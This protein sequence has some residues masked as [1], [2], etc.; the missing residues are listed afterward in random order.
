M[1]SGIFTTI[2]RLWSE[3]RKFIHGRLREFG[4]GS[5]QIEEKIQEELSCLVEAI[6]QFE[7]KPFDPNELFKVSVS[8]IICSILF[9]ERFDYESPAFKKYMVDLNENLD[10]ITAAGPL[11]IFPILRHLPGDPFKYKKLL[12]NISHISSFFDDQIRAHK[13]RKT[14]NNKEDFIDAYLEQIEKEKNNPDTT[15]SGKRIYIY[16]VR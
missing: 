9:G 16:V 12:E 5:S 4:V 7:S 10:L 11:M 6:S 14:P 8:N 1:L 13:E 15:F 3:Q 2:G